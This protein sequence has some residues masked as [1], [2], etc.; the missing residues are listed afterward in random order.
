MTTSL[1]LPLPELAGQFLLEPDV[2]FLNH[3]SFGAC[4]RPVFDTYHRWQRELEAQPVEFLGRRLRPLLAEARARLAA[5]VG[6]GADDLVFVPNA[7]FGINIVARSLALGPGDE[8]LATDHEY[9]AADKTWRFLCHERGASYINQPIALPVT[10]PAAMVEQL[11]AGVTERTKVI[12]LSHITSPT[13]LRFPVAEVCRRA[14]AA[15][16]MTVVDGAHA[17]GQVE[18]D[19]GAIGADFYAGNCHKWLCAPKGAGFLHARP[20]RQALLQPLIVSWGWEAARPGPSSF[21][22]YY[23]WTGTTDPSAFLSV[24]AAI[25]F[26]TQ[27]NWPAVRAAC[28]QLLL[29][30]SSWIAELTGLPHSSPDSADWWV[31]M[32]TLPL[33]PYDTEQVKVRL[34]DEFRVEVP[35][36][37]WG[38]QQ[39]VRVSIQAYNTPADIDRLLEG[40][41][42]VLGL[43]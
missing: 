31:Q 5:Y 38:G 13:A 18:L 34:W 23:E 17:P 36:G 43:R 42:H 27:H 29:D 9:G 37:E 14:R 10:T 19:L 28:H 7:T 22:D 15:G 35:L 21:L 20:E 2:A 1:T 33:P 26:Q 41:K 40:L 11:W 24:P 39:S 12:F 3:G 30:A 16:I 8:V 32:R 6:A 25:D 4:P